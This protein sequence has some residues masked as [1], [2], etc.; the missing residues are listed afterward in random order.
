M[1]LSI[2]RPASDI[3][4]TGDSSD[5]FED[6]WTE[7]QAQGWGVFTR[8]SDGQYHSTERIVFGDDTTPTNVSDIDCCVKFGDGKYFYTKDNAKVT[9]G[10]K[11][12][13]ETAVKGCFIIF[14]D[15]GDDAT[16]I[17]MKGTLNLYNTSIKQILVGGDIYHAHQLNL[18]GA[19][20]FIDSQLRFLNAINISTVYTTYGIQYEEFINGIRVFDDMTLT[21][22]VS[23]NISAGAYNFVPNRSDITVYLVNP[24]IG[25]GSFFYAWSIIRADTYVRGYSTTLTWRSGSTMHVDANTYQQFPFNIHVKDKDGNNLSE[26]TCLLEDKDDAEAFSVETAGSGKIVQQWVNYKTYDSTN[27]TT[28]GATKTPHKLTLSKA[29]YETLV[30][31]NIIIDE[32]KDL[33]FE[34]LPALAESDVRYDTDFGENKTGKCH[35]PAKVDVRKDVDVDVSDSGLLDL[36]SEDDTRYGVTFDNETKVG[37]C[38]LPPED[39]TAEGETYGTDGTE[40]IGTFV[41]NEITGAI[42]EGQATIGAVVGQATAGIVVA[43]E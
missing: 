33:E 31:D 17:E 20:E 26:V 41:R 1:A 35:V 36:A 4:V 3:I 38:V 8:L 9:L 24:K 37:N 11:L 43:G 25:G 27:Y 19:G 13:S 14:D 6:I 39:R 40:F 10:E 22:F 23:K 21:N 28:G 7:D 12:D 32:A 2:T 15:L 29:G 5:I 18:N 16:S 30:I 34:L 42:I